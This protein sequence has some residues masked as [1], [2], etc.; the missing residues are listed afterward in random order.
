MDASNLAIVLAPNIIRPNINYITPT[1]GNPFKNQAGEQILSR[2]YN[3]LD[4]MLVNTPVLVCSSPNINFEGIYIMSMLSVHAEFMTFSS[5][6]LYVGIVQLLI[7]N[8][9]WIGRV[10]PEV[11]SLSE[12]IQ[13]DLAQSR[14]METV[15]DGSKG[16][17]LPSRYVSSKDKKQRTSSLSGI[18]MWDDKVSVQCS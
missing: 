17:D 1:Q 3:I 15:L 8:S 13:G 2:V 4:I 10:S 12:T 9:R 11:C 16:H 5:F 7:E 18:C 14:S 6:P